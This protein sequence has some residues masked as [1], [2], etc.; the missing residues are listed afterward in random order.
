M[1]SIRNTDNVRNL[2]LID[3]DVQEY[4]VFENHANKN[5]FWIRYDFCSNKTDL[6]QVMDNLF[7]GKNIDRIAF[8]FNNADIDNK[9]FLN[10]ERFFS[11]SDLNANNTVYSPNC[12]F[13][14]D[15]I[16]SRSV[17]HVDFLACYSLQSEKWR[18]YYE[19]LNIKTGAIIGA[20]NDETGNIIVLDQLIKVM[21]E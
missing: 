18:K 14:I 6:L 10:G 15:L 13:I 3:S 20:S 1:Y 19:L 11:E 8:V 4:D 21:A 12:Q 5:T 7:N 9:R 17:Q 2:I 16:I